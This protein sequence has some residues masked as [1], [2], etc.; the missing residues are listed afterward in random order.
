M[1]NHATEG[2]LTWFRIFVEDV[3]DREQLVDMVSDVLL[4][5]HVSYGRG[6]WQ[7]GRENDAVVEVYGPERLRGTVVTL[8]T[9]LKAAF[10]QEAVGVAEHN[11]RVNFY[12]V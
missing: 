8:A 5:A 7:G 2:P 9:E 3:G 12:L 4:S 11:D 1:N 10:Q 6:V